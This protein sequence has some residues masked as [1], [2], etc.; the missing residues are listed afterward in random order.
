MPA[1]LD[2]ALRPAK[3]SDQ[4]VAEPRL[5]AL[6]IVRRIH[7]G[8]NRIGRDPAVERTDQA[9]EAVFTDSGVQIEL[10]QRLVRLGAPPDDQEDADRDRDHQDDCG[11]ADQ[12]EQHDE[13]E[14]LAHASIVLRAKLRRRF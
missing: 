13:V 12:R 10:V 6:Q 1:L 11:R 5:G 7:G 4:E 3:A 8:Q 2:V 9:P 14:P